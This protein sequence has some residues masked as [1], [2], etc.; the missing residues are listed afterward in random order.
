ME[1]RGG[2]RADLLLERGL[3]SAADSQRLPKLLER[4]GDLLL[5]LVRPLLLGLHSGARH[6]PLLV[7]LAHQ[8]LDLRGRFS[9]RHMQLLNL[10][11]L[12][13]NH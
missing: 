10:T 4:E 3:S 1:S 6:L 5:R 7:G 13:A 9:D 2:E 11:L 12:C 8:L